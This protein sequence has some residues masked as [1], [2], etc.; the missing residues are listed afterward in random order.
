MIFCYLLCV[1]FAKVVAYH[2][3]HRKDP[4]RE[5]TNAGKQYHIRSIAEHYGVQTK[6]VG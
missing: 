3:K 4:L 1:L 2:P 6:E 5:T